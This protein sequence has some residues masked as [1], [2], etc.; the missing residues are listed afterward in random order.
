[1]TNYLST[2]L[3]NRERL[4]SSLVLAAAVL[5]AAWMGSANGGYFIGD[6]APVAFIL[7]VLMLLA[8]VTG[9]LGRVQSLWSVAATSLLTGYTAWTFVSLIWSPNQGDAWFGAT[10]TLFYLLA[11][12][13]V[14]AF[15]TLGASR[16]WALAASSI[17]PALVAAFTLPNLAPNIEDLFQNNRLVGSV[18]YY[19]GEAAFLLVP[20]WVSVYLAGSRRVNP[21]VRGVVLAG[22]VLG[23]EVAVLT[24]SRGAMVAIAVSLPVFFLFS[25]KRL[26]GL[27]ALVPI[28]AALFVAFP[29][30][31]QV[32]LEFLN[33]GSPA[34]AVREVVPTVWLTAIGAGV[35]GLLWGLLDSWW[36][37]PVAVARTAG[38]VALAGVMVVIVLGGFAL[39]ERVGE[40]VTWGQE[41][42]GAFKTNDTSGQEQSRYLSASGS[43]R[44]ELWE[45]AWDD[46]VSNP[47]LG[48]GTYNYEA[49]YYQKRDEMVGYSRWP[50]ML[51]LEVLAER[52]VIGGM[53]FFG[54]LGTCLA[55]GLWKRFTSLN[56]EGKA[57][58]GA[59]VA[60][61][62]YWFVHSSAEWFWQLPAIT[63]L[64]I[65]YLAMLVAPW[66]RPETTPTGWS[67]RAAGAGIAVLA[68]ATIA[69]L[70][71]ADRYLAQ[72]LADT[73]P[74]T[75]L[76][77]VE[78]AQ[79]FN[80]LHPRLA[81]REAELATKIGDWPRAEKA[82]KREIR[83]NPE[84]YVSYLLLAQFYEQRGETEKA[85]SFYREALERNPIDPQLKESVSRLQEQVKGS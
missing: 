3:K 43:G 40:P 62:A 38:A 55:A 4:A 49:T 59:M 29:G 69:P 6:R 1:M 45:V 66:N 32:Y 37:P 85:L 5:L 78:Q 31:N 7:T 28:V 11:F 65:V 15:V 63:M 80:P 26:R 54:F 84:H 81:Q 50:H 42:W 22:A 60:A 2:L 18:G 35:Y 16:R 57:Q 39:T 23:A 82:Y 70:Y 72:S 68:I 53:L 34:A 12:W 10:T 46:F 74:W 41:K 9:V 14:L 76:E 58:V 30:L 52:G 21:L 61:I 20:F 56:A 73:N 24:Q 27:L 13:V 44:Y 8:S 36:R 77:K 19:N 75:S 71:I 83:L 67:V 47:A 79:K 33:E 25:G 17:G 51:P 48:I 64:A